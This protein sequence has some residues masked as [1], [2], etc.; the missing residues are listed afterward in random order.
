[1]RIRDTI[2]A[3][4]LIVAGSALAPAAAETIRLSAT[5]SGTNEAPANDS[6]AAGTTEASYDTETRMLT[7]RVE[8]GGL[9]GPAIGAHFHGPAEAGANAG[10]VVRFPRNES[11]IEGSSEL[12]D[13]QAEDLLAGRWYTNIHTQQHPGGE[14]RGQLER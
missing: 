8:Y 12:T 9:S 2:L 5:L 7:Y 3:T 1:M 10:I 14:L 11:P 13:Q 6:A 4:A